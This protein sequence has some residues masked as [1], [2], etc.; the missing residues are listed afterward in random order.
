VTEQQERRRSPGRPAIALDRIVSTA[1]EIV[2]EQG[3][4]ALSMRALAQRLDSGT[5]TLYRHFSGRA[6][7]VAHVIDR[8]FGTAEVDVAALSALPWPEACKAAARSMFDALQQHK[9]V[10]PLLVGTVPVGPNALAARE[11]MIAFLLA[12]GFSPDLAARSY[13]LVSRYVLGFAIQLTGTRTGL[14]DV[15]L[16]RMFHDLD[17]SQFPATVAVADHLPVPFD[18]EFDFGLE[19]IVNGLASALTHQTQPKKGKRRSS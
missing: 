8:V 4:E 6:D 9:N 10:T 14:D 3:A 15:S 11:Q 19:L 17:A 16:A 2:D 7:V 1:L 13:A 5:A 18:E 12:S